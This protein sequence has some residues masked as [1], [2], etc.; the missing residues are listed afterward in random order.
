LNKKLKLNVDK[1]V[2]NMLILM[3]T[4]ALTSS[5]LATHPVYAQNGGVQVNPPQVV[6]DSTNGTIGTLFNLTVT[7]TG[8]TD[9][10]VWQVKMAFNVSMINVTRW[11]EP[12]TDTS[13]V[14]YGQSTLPVPAPPKTSYN[15]ES[16][17]IAYLGIGSALFPAPSPGGG[18]TG[19]GLLC[20]LTFNIT[21]TPPPGQIYTCNFFINYPTGTF[22]IKTGESSKRAFDTYNGGQYW[23]IPEL[24]PLMI[25][26]TLAAAT[27]VG[28][29]ARK[30]IRKT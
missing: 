5:M 3:I 30:H 12:T 1:S 13:Y 18:F 25:L 29:R 8:I 17:D 6:Y 26:A 10:K 22:W 23:F 4:L 24:A 2:T 15:I 7:V 16:G 11:Y 14:F 28:V 27:I 9:M 20:I 21:A 19:D